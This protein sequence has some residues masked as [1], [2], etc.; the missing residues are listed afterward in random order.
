VNAVNNSPRPFGL[1]KRSLIKAC[2]KSMYHAVKGLPHRIIVLG[3]K[4]SDEMVE[5][6]SHYDVEFS[7]GNY[8]NDESIRQTIK[9]ALGLPDEEWIYFCE[10]DY[11]HRPETFTYINNLIAQKNTVIVSPKRRLFSKAFDVEATD[12]VIFPPDYPDRYFRRF[13]KQYYIYHST[14]CH[15]RQVANVTFTM[16]AQAKLIKKHEALFMQSSV[17]ANDGHLSRKLFGELHFNNKAICLSPLPGL[18]THMHIDTMTPLV[19][20]DA[21]KNKYTDSY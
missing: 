2:F 3:D 9:I 5:F 19:D 8:G 21:I 4:V 11:L 12:L 16:F 7:N 1:D 13:I 15:W 14:D 17:G 10:D 6:F 18:S 20:W